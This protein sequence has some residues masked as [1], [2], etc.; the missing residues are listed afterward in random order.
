[1]QTGH[2]M[3]DA[4]SCLS[5]KE[6]EAGIVSVVYQRTPTLAPFFGACGWRLVLPGFGQPYFSLNTA[7]AWPGAGIGGQE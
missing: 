5:T 3:C 1:M 6:L 4:D 7:R 2:P